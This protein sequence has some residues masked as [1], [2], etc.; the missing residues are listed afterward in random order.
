MVEK[1]AQ[2]LKTA[3]SIPAVDMHM[4]RHQIKNNQLRIQFRKSSSRFGKNT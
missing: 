2:L 1:A 4:K 3:V